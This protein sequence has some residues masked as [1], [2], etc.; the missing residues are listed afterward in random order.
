MQSVNHQFLEYAHQVKAR[1]IKTRLEPISGWRL[2]PG[3]TRQTERIDF[4]LV[5][6]EKNI[7]IIPYAVNETDGTTTGTQHKQMRFSY[8]DEV[9]ELY[10]DFEVTAFERM[11][12]LLIENGLLRSYH[13][14]APDIKRNNQLSEIDIDTIIKTKSL[15]ALRVRIAE[16]T[17][18][19]ILTTILQRMKETD[20]ITMAHLRIVEEK[21]QSLNT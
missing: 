7:D 5:T 4:L 21:I 20:T 1:Y 19:D 2:Q 6:P 16:I 3:A 18:R 10:T 12:R 13:Q 8:E 11:N 14:E 9:L 15:S 17:S